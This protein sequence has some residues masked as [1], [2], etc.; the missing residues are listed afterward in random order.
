MAKRK[1]FINVHCRFKNTK[2]YVECSQ[3]IPLTILFDDGVVL[4]NATVGLG[5]L[6]MG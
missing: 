5:V 2:V 3:N 1:Q 4:D 6:G